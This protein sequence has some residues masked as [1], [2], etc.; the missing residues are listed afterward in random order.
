MDES[1]V[2]VSFIV[3]A[4]DEEELLPR[5]L[6][7]LRAAEREVSDSVEIVVVDDASTDRTGEIA[8]QAGARVVS[9]NH[10][11][12]SRTRN[13][14][15]RAA[16]GRYLV[17]VDAD[18]VVTARV[19]RSALIALR[20]GAVGGGSRLRFD[21]E[22]PRWGRVIQWSANHVYAR[23][24]LAS[25]SFLF[26]TRES[27]ERAGGFDEALYGAEEAAFSRALG[28]LGPFVSLRDEVVTSG[29]KLRAYSARE[30]LGSL[31]RLAAR[32]S[33]LRSPEAP[34]LAVWY[35][36]RRTDPGAPSEAACR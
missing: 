9:V 8:R 4:Y 24:G 31:L 30:I 17:F 11:Q 25:G 33:R 15:A 27:F 32:P 22:V 19:V 3:P 10:R 16:R 13:A 5:T 12:I 29:R 21:G 23:A 35:G 20:R 28:K 18:T 2:D 34:E 36:D 1:R 6:Q 14:G 7:A 26:C